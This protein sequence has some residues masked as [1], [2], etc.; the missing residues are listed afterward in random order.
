MDAGAIRGD[1]TSKLR[2]PSEAATACKVCGGSAAP[3][4]IVDFNRSC[5]EARGLRLPRTGIP[6]QYHR[7]GGCGLVFTDTFDAWDQADFEAHVYNDA[8]AMV[9]PDYAAARPQN[10]AAGV[11][12]AFGAASAELDVLDYGG[13]NGR[14]AEVLRGAG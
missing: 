5:E 12:G 2:A 8:Y 11:I 3:M 7:C 4:G 9:D 14:C 6:V 10:M 13:G 1:L